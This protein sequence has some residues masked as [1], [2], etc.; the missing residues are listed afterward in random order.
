VLL[1]KTG[2]NRKKL[3]ELWRWIKRI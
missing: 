1:Q 2:L 3:A